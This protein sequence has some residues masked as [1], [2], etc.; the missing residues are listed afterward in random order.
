MGGTAV[1]LGGHHGKGRAGSR[2]HGGGT[3]VPW[4]LSAH[5]TTPP[6][7]SPAVDDQTAR[8]HIRG[9]RLRPSPHPWAPWTLSPPSNSD[10]CIPCPCRGQAPQSPAQVVKE[11][12]SCLS[13]TRELLELWIKHDLCPPE[14]SRLSGE[15]HVEI[16]NTEHWF[17]NEK[18]PKCCEKAGMCKKK[19]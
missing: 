16:I 4:I 9:F 10:L 19:L 12:S 11:T 7:P 6:A 1:S 8:N 5:R 2:Q 18:G 13:S 17:Q 14:A 3:A 15:T